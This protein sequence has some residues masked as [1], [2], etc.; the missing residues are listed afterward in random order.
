MYPCCW[1]DCSTFQRMAP[2]AD[3]MSR[4]VRRK[5]QNQLSEESSDMTPSHDDS[6]EA[7]QHGLD[8][9]DLH[10]WLSQSQSAHIAE[11]TLQ[12]DES[13]VDDITVSTNNV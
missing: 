3:R 8:D 2:A 10:L 11:P 6:R 7:A 4:R 12:L 9:D 1:P 5:R 13:T